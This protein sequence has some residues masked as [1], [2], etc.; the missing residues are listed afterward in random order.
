LMYHC[1]DQWF[2]RIKSFKYLYCTY[3]C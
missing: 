2:C 1:G 3:D